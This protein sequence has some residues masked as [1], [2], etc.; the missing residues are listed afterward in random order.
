MMGSRESK[1]DSECDCCSECAALHNSYPM[2][3]SDRRSR[4]LHST[5]KGCKQVAY[6]SRSLFNRIVRDAPNFEDIACNRRTATNK[7]DVLCESQ[8]D[9]PPNY[10]TSDGQV[11]FSPLSRFTAIGQVRKSSANPTTKSYQKWLPG[12]VSESDIFSQGASMCGDHNLFNCPISNRTPWFIF[13]PKVELN[14][15]TPAG[16][17]PLYFEKVN[18]DFLGHKCERCTTEQDVISLFE[19]EKLERECDAACSKRLPPTPKVRKARLIREIQPDT[20][21]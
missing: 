21:A 20:S 9:I 14:N 4:R 16:L 6:R 18:K 3:R 10:T 5:S 2:K 12:V 15:S 7:Y 13:L 17:T 1:S 19:F 8:P 11:N